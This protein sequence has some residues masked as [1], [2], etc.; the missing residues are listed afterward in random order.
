MGRS[1][2]DSVVRPGADQWS[3]CRGQATFRTMVGSRQPGRDQSALD[4]P[5]SGA[6]DGCPAELGRPIRRAVH[7][8]LDRRDADGARHRAGRRRRRDGT[9][10]RAVGRSRFRGRRS[11]HP[12]QDTSA[13]SCRRR[14]RR[15]RTRRWLSRRPPARR[16]PARRSPAHRFP[17]RDDPPARRPIRGFEAGPRID[18]EERTPPVHRVPPASGLGARRGGP[19]SGPER[20]RRSPDVPIRPRASA[21]SLPGSARRGTR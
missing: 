11:P 5:S 14:E 8:P 1:V 21:P 15:M 7:D 4:I 6:A 9:T 10:G 3:V 20:R 2:D 13:P 19:S 18:A 12:P 16:F 17:A